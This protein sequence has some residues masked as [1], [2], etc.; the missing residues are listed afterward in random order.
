MFLSALHRINP[1]RIDRTVSQKIRQPHDIFIR[2]VILSGEQMSQ[3]VRI[4]LVGAD[5]RQNGQTFHIIPY[6]YPI[7]RIAVSRA[8]YRT[9][10]NF[11]ILCVILQ[12][13]TEFSFHI[14]TYKRCRLGLLCYCLTS[15][16]NFCFFAR[17]DSL[18][19]Q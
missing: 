1:G 13:K 2:T 16:V 9:A 3:I 6:I 17:K 8:E 19:N 18:L 14:A 10:V 12:E 4:N 5:S 15:K 7:Q 11:F